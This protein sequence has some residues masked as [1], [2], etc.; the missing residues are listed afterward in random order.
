MRPGKLACPPSGCVNRPQFGFRW[1]E[2]ETLPL[3]QRAALALDSR[4]G[5]EEAAALLA[6]AQGRE[7]LAL[8]EWWPLSCALIA[9]CA[10]PAPFLDSH[11]VGII[12][13][14]GCRE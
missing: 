13:T 14:K 2:I 10:Q 1:I 4:L 3:T 9:G 6:D 11:R 8:R 5:L 12:Q 7:R